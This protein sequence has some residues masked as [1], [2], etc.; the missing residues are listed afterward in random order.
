MPDIY[1]EIEIEDMIYDE[2]DLSYTYPCPCGD[3][4]RVTLEELHD[5]DDIAKCPSCTLRI[6]VIYDVD[7][8][9]ELPPDDEEE[10]EDGV[11]EKID[12]IAEKVAAI[13]VSE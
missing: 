6:R 3:L 2:N 9:P 4:F 11:E 8:L 13:K 7:D 10:E 12:G 5:G 1:E